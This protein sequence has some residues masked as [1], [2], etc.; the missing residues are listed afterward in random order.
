MSTDLPDNI[1]S[2]RLATSVTVIAHT[3]DKEDSEDK[4]SPERSD[5]DGNVV[6]E[7]E[8]DNSRY[9][10]AEFKGF[11]NDLGPT[12]TLLQLKLFRRSRIA[13]WEYAA[14]NSSVAPTRVEDLVVNTN[15]HEATTPTADNPTGEA[16]SVVPFLSYH[17]R[18]PPRHLKIIGMLFF[19]VANII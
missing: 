10:L 19:F 13:V 5:A 8:D 12:S 11:V 9:E 1:K 14:I 3:K 17:W 15:P 18:P 4:A 16:T 7:K 6:D 2:P